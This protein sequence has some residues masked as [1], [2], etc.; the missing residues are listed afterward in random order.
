MQVQARGWVSGECNTG[1]ALQAIQLDADRRATVACTAPSSAALSACRRLLVASSTAALPLTT[2]TATCLLC[3]NLPPAA[4]QPC[5]PSPQPLRLRCH[6]PPAVLPL[7]APTPSVRSYLYPHLTGESPMPT[8][9]MSAL[10]K[11]IEAAHR[12]ARIYRLI[13]IDASRLQCSASPQADQGARPS[14]SCAATSSCL[15][16]RTHRYRVG[17]PGR[18]AG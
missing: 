10:T 1:S 18:R 14:R 3:C 15:Q 2:C 5:N 6:L 16:G 7:P 13:G 4:L 12:W 8:S 17:G 11:E 9:G